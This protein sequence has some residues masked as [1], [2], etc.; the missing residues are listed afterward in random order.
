[1]KVAIIH[2]F[3]KFIHIYMSFEQNHEIL[4]N[5]NTNYCMEIKASNH[6]L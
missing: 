4:K 5:M 3:E 1:M 2:V 6:N